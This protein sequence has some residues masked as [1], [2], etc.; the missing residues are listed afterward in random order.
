MRTRTMAAGRGRRAS[1][2]L[3]S[4]F[5]VLHRVIVE[6]TSSVNSGDQGSSSLFLR[7]SFYLID[8]DDA[9]ISRLGALS[10]TH[11]LARARALSLLLSSLPPPLLP[12]P[13]ASAA[14]PA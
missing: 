8:D 2:Y 13:P 5:S 10:R 14:C 9:R 6:G 7:L 3:A 1:S 4:S 11:S 12:R